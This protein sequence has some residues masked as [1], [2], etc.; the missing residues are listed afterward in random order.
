MILG[1]DISKWQDDFTTPQEIN[2]NVMKSAG[3]QFV[4]IKASQAKFTDKLFLNS[5]SDAK[6]IIPRGAY[7]YLDYS[8]PA[9]QQAIYFCSVIKDDPGELPPVVDFECRTNVPAGTTGELWNFVIY[10][11]EHTGRVPIIYTGPYYW[12]E[13]GS[14]NIGWKKYPLWIANYQVVK[15]LIPAP[16]TDFL[17]WQYT[18]K[19]NGLQYGVE[20][21]QID[22]N[23]FNGTNNDLMTFCGSTPPAPLSQEQKVDLLYE[24]GKLHGWTLP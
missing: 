7:H 16:W 17:F 22:L 21:K 18:N 11:E 8:I 6:G 19:G 20:S 15:P 12:Y 9:I 5:W 4:F 14:K 24:Q 1:T 3:A 10:V 13:F 23:W 2:F